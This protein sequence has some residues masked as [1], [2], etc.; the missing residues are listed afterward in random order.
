LFLPRLEIQDKGNIL[1][2]LPRR[3]KEYAN[4]KKFTFHLSRLVS[5]LIFWCIAFSLSEN[6]PGPNRN[7]YRTVTLSICLVTTVICGGFTD[8]VLTNLGMKEFN[9][10]ICEDR[11]GVNVQNIDLSSATPMEIGRVHEDFRSVWK[12][13]NEK[14]LK[15]CFGGI[16]CSN[17]N[18]SIED[19]NL[20]NYEMQ[21]IRIGESCIN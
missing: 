3:Q 11:D 1:R 2:A 16:S 15:A 7:T 19:N 6:M 8:K 20:V 5:S 18:I 10:N 21:K 12:L 17:N 4:N 9:P 14:Y 13:L